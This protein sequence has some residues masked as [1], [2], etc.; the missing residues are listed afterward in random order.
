[1]QFSP[2][3][4]SAPAAITGAGAV[5]FLR[6]D[7]DLAGVAPPLDKGAPVRGEPDT[8]YRGARVLQIPAP[9][10]DRML[11]QFSTRPPQQSDSRKSTS[12]VIVA[13]SAA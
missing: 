11:S 8:T 1:M 9:S 5:R 13:M 4:E 2:F 12:P 7:Q 6:P 10:S 3:A